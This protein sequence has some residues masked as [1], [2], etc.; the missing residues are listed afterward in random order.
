MRI[1]TSDGELRRL[2]SSGA[3]LIYNDFSGTGTSGS[4]YNVL[5]HASCYQLRHANLNVPKLHFHSLAEARAWLTANRG[6]ENSNWKRY[7]TC[8][9][10]PAS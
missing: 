5:H 4:E 1:I 3:G 2:R 6:P 8:Q 10:A 9:A 7:G